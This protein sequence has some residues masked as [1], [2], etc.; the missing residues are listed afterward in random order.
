MQYAAPTLLALLAAAPPALA[1]MA[2]A[3]ASACSGCPGVGGGV[4]IT[5]RPAQDTMAILAQFRD[6]S[7]K[8]TIMNRI[9]AG[10]TQDEL[11]AIAQW[12][13]LQP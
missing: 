12:L 4:A 8:S 9:V 7:R 13:A 3:G 5:A 2:P 10:F 11:Q 6:G 1:S